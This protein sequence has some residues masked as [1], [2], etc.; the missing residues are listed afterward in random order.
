[1]VMSPTRRGRSRGLPCWWTEWREGE[2]RQLLIASDLSPSALFATVRIR[3]N[4]VRIG[5]S[6][7]VP[8]RVVLAPPRPYSGG[9]APVASGSDAAKG[10]E[11]AA[12]DQ[13]PDAVP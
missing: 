12:R 5:S 13:H 4:T 6:V 10:R 1:G 9:N 2:F 8:L 11:G 3:S 7:R